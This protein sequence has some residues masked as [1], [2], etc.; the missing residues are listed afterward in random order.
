MTRPDT[1]GDLLRSRIK[2]ELEDSFDEE[3]EI[4]ID[5]NRLDKILAETDDHPK[6]TSI[7]RRVYF[8]EL[9]RL[10]GEVVKMQDWI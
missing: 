7:D 8:K 4:E 6:G 2:S 10:Q 9:F 5:D 3:L 1:N